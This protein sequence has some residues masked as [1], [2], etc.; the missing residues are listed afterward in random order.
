MV[1]RRVV[2]KA[3]E[4]RAPNTI[5]MIEKDKRLPLRTPLVKDTL[6]KWNAPGEYTAQDSYQMVVYV[7][8]NAAAYRYSSLMAGAFVILRVASRVGYE[9]WF[10][11]GLRNALPGSTDPLKIREYASMSPEEFEKVV[12]PEGDYVLIDAEMETLLPVIELIGKHPKIGLRIA[13]NSVR[14]YNEMFSKDALMD[15]T[16]RVINGLSRGQTWTNSYTVAEMVPRLVEEPAESK[17]FKQSMRL[18]QKRQE[19]QKELQE[20]IEAGETKEEE[21]VEEVGLTEMVRPDVS[22]AKKSTRM[23]VPE[24]TIRAIVGKSIKTKAETLK[25]LPE[26]PGKEVEETPRRRF[27][28]GALQTIINR[29]IRKETKTGAEVEAETE[30]EVEE[31]RIAIGEGESKEE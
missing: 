28:H 5:A 14:R 13:T 4:V 1:P 10:Y 6:G 12:D 18:Q 20:K 2:V 19:V 25:P 16:S 17:M 23:D 21:A 8:G 9:M 31:E 3:T 11:S 7:D 30:K 27:V 24:Q 15:V 29:T 22:V 26:K